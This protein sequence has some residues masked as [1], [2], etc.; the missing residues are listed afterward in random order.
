MIG[1]WVTA[2]KWLENPFRI[3]R[4]LDSSIYF[5]GVTVSDSTVGPFFEDELVPIPL[6]PEILEKNGFGYFSIGGAEKWY[7]N[8]D[9]YDLCICEWS[10]SIWVLGYD[11]TEMNIPRTQVIFSYIHELQHALRLCGINKEIQK[12]YK[13]R[14]C[15]EK[16]CQ[17]FLFFK[18][19]FAFDFIHFCQP[20]F[21][22]SLPHILLVQ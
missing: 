5:Y 7:I 11:S 13:P 2:K 14:Q 22:P 16:A 3:T 18:G 12:S 21:L 6:T 17:T 19:S 4:I 8:D 20:D 9:Y 1:D 15:E 10:D